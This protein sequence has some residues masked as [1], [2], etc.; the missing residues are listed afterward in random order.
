[1]FSLITIIQLLHP[2]AKGRPKV[3]EGTSIA[4]YILI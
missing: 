2:I 3:I 1:V 4:L